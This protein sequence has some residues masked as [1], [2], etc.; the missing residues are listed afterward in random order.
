[1]APEGSTCRNVAH[2]AS[3][4]EIRDDQV[5]VNT[6][7][8][9]GCDVFT[10]AADLRKQSLGL[11]TLDVPTYAGRC[12]DTG[13]DRTIRDRLNRVAAWRIDD[14]LLSLLDSTE[15]LLLVYGPTP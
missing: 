10:G 5:F 1:M 11:I 15:S 13:V 4:L 9:G 6:G 14:G 12:W 7:V 3:S 8:G 2:L